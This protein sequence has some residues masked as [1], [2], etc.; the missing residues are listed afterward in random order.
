[1]QNDLQNMFQ[2]VD[3]SSW[4]GY[5]QSLKQALEAGEAAGISHHLMERAASF[6]GEYLAQK[7]EPDLPENRAL[8]ELWQVADNKEKRTIASLV[9]KLAKKS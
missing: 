5:K 1:M 7:V 4:D 9:V 8:K 3:D 6:A 2:A